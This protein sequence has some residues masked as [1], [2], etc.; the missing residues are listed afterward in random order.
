M[1]EHGGFDAQVDMPSF[2]SIIGSRTRKVGCGI[3]RV[4]ES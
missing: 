3:G 1:L 4:S 2:E